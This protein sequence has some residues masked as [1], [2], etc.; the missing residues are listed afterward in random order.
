MRKKI[1]IV[2][3]SATV[4]RVLETTL[5]GA[6][7]DVTEAVDG[8]E[9]LALAGKTEF[10]LLM[11]DLNMPKMDGF[12]LVREFRKLNGCRFTPTIML[13]NEVNVLK[14][15]ESYDIGVSGWLNKPFHPNQV[16]RILKMVAPPD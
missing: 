7:Y 16:L 9:A 5:S 6:G 2:D 15:I 1:L 11:T 4:R 10:D 3:D 8:E 14:K 13:T 12:D